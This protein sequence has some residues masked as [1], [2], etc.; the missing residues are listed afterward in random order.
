MHMD[1]PLYWLRGY[2]VAGEIYTM[3]MIS[4]AK[5]GFLNLDGYIY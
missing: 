2:G 4:F 5:A 3:C 1:R